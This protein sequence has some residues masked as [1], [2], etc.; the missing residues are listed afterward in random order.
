MHIERKIV[1]FLIVVLLVLTQALGVIHKLDSSA[2]EHGHECELCAHLSNIDHGL[3]AELPTIPP[4]FGLVATE[5]V[6]QRPVFTPIN[7]PYH[8]RAPPFSLSS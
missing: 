4:A 2:H 6:A 1:S 8:S 7:L 3:S 5:I